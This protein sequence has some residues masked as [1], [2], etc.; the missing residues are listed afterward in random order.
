MGRTLRTLSDMRA[1]RRY[2]N[3]IIIDNWHHLKDWYSKN[4]PSDTHEI[5]FDDH[6]ARIQVRKELRDKT[7]YYG[8]YGNHYHYLSTHTFYGMGIWIQSTEQ[9]YKAGF[10][11]IIIRNWDAKEENQEWPKETWTS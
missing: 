8:T 1:E 2:K 10:K 7:G 9:L 3:A 4:G 11:G 5:V 6:S